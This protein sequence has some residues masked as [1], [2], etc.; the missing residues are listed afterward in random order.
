MP[1]IGGI[2]SDRAAYAYLP[3]STSYLPPA[4]EMLAALEAGGFLGARHRTFLFGAVQLLTAERKG[5]A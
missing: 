1:W 5:D 3:Q 2:L 4:G